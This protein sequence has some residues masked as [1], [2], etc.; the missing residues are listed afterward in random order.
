MTVPESG[1]TEAYC[2]AC[3]KWWLLDM[4]TFGPGAIRSTCEHCKTAWEIRIGYYE[5]DQEFDQE[6]AR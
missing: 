4:P 5:F 1:M 3:G 2:P 6:A